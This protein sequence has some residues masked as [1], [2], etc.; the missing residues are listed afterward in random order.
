MEIT[1]R[2]QVDAIEEEMK[3]FRRAIH[4]NPEIS[5]QEFATCE[6][7]A[8]KLKEIGVEVQT[9]TDKTGVIGLIKGGNPGKTIALRADIDALP[10]Q[11]ATDL[12]FS[13]KNSMV[14]HACG[15]DIHATVLLGC[16][17]ILNQRR[18]E[19]AGNVK[20]IFQPAEE[21]LSG[22][23]SMIEAGAL[24]NPKVDVIIAL[25][26]WP[27]LPAGS[28]GVKKGSFMASADTLDITIHGRAGHAAHPHKSID[29][30]VIAGHV[31]SSLQTIVSR[32]VSPIDSAVITIGKINGG[33][34]ANII[35]DKV[36]MAGTVRTINKSLRDKMPSM[37]ERV[38]CKTAESMNG[39][40]VVSYHMGTPP[41]MNN[42]E[43]VA[44]I[45]KTAKEALSDENVLTLE[46]A[47]MGGEDFAFYLEKIPG[48]MFR[49]GTSNSNPDTCLA[50]HNPKLI[51]DEQAIS[52]GT[53]V[54]CEAAEAFL[55]NKKD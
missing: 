47:S 26:C 51:F 1:I 50:L 45:E 17:K 23:K 40:A 53:L 16:A 27:D 48:A 2:E 35:A 31:I 46:S 22:A 24:E 6:L 25:H 43:L 12:E 34:A 44:L 3:A 19:I 5:E 52:T 39:S 32:E 7:I 11:E 37:I 28:V 49:L 20:L 29:P 4:K 10:L 42:E 21:N 30:I 38:V 55:R 54:M 13:S 8:N 18:G 14:A 41:L 33:T 15:H 9:F 36:D